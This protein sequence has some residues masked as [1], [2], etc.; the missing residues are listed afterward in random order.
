[1]TA[2]VAKVERV[3]AMGLGTRNFKSTRYSPFL[4]EIYL[5]VVNLLTL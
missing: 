1:M 5:K 2:A 4:L 3:T